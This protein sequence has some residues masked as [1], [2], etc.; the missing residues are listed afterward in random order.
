MY[1]STIQPSDFNAAKA[2]VPEQISRTVAVQLE[3]LG[4]L[5]AELEHAIGELHECLTPILADEET[6]DKPCVG[7][8]YPG[9]RSRVA[10]EAAKIRDSIALCKDRIRA[11]IPRIDV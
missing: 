1:S 3:V 9:A 2:G 7:V 5:T 8:C 10:G 4:K 6:P 11:L